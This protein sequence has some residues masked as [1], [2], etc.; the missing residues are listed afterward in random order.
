MAF[1]FLPCT[2][3]CIT[4]M[5]NSGKTRFVYRLLTHLKEMYAEE[6]PEAILYCFGIHQPLFEEMEKTIPNIVFHEGLPT[7][8]TVREFTADRRHRLIVLDDL[9]HQ[10]VRNVDME[11]LFTQGCHHR[12]LSVLF[13]TQN[14][15]VQ[16]S[17]SRTIA[18]NTTYLVLMKNVRDVSQIVT[19]GRQLYP[20]R[21]K[22]LMK[23]FSDATSRDYGY[24]IVDLAPN[25]D[26]TY[27]LRTH[28]F[29]GEDT[30]IYIPQK[31]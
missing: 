20:G 12:R 9:M 24:L 26:D 15:Y 1:P 10:V 7:M 5:T 28:V 11:L 14:L 21:W 3:M 29:P 22:I 2:S 8:D 17:R 18:L 31:L 6:P 30:V 16:G 25:S 13:L 23:S 19:L 4:G 27:R